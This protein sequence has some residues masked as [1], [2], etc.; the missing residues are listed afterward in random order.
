MTE[1]TTFQVLSGDTWEVQADTKEQAL[2][3]FEA[4][5][6]NDPC[7]CKVEDCEC[8]RFGEASTIVVG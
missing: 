7:P 3:K 2:A 5:C 8:V 4:F 6:E 1:K